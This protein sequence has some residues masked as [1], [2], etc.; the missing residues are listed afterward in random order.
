[1]RQFYQAFPIG[2]TVCDLLS[3]SHYRLLIRVENQNA[4]NWYEKEAMDQNWS[5][6]ALERQINTLYY[7]RLLV[8]SEKAPVLREAK[9]KTGA[10]NKNPE[11]FIKDPYVLEFLDIKDR[12]EFRESELEQA[13]IDKLQAF[14]LELGQGFAFVARQKRVSSQTKEF[15]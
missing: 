6:R 7:E 12:S 4:R 15:F 2:H 8:S 3:W 10:L 5:V 14:L 11:H 1:M 13:I 9:E